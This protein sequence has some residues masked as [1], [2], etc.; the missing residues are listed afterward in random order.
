MECVFDEVESTG[1]L[2]TKYHNIDFLSVGGKRE[3]NILELRYGSWEAFDIL[4]KQYSCY[5]TV[6]EL[7]QPWMQELFNVDNSEPG[8]QNDMCNCLR[9]KILYNDTNM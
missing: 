1:K 7:C 4:R 3:Y 6:D 8:T 5:Q 9:H 2:I